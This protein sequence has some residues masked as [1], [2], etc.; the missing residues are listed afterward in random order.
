MKPST[1]LT[2]KDCQAAVLRH[3]NGSDF[4][5][6]E[7]ERVL[8]TSAL[9]TVGFAARRASLKYRVQTLS[10]TELESAGFEGV[11]QALNSYLDPARPPHTATFST[12]C[13]RRVEGAIREEIHREYQAPDATEELEPLF[14]DPRSDARPAAEYLAALAEKA[15]VTGEEIEL[16]M[17]RTVD[18][19]RLREITDG[20]GAAIVRA[21]RAEHR[22]IA[23]LKEAAAL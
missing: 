11:M 15:G 8:V 20:T 21:H 12:F 23:K 22:A 5:R 6:R 14:T 19:K 9:A 1:S 2:L 7:V 4:D 16:L 3:R 10:L 13:Q 17:L 18:G